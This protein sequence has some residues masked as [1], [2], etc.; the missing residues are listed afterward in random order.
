MPGMRCWDD[1][2]TTVGLPRIKATRPNAIARSLR[3]VARVAMAAITAIAAS[4]SSRD[5]MATPLPTPNVSEGPV[6]AIVPRRNALARSL[7][8][9]A[10]PN[11]QEALR[12]LPYLS[13]AQHEA[14]VEAARAPIARN[15]GT[16][17]ASD[18]GATELVTSLVAIEGQS[19]R[20]D[21]GAQLRGAIA[22]ASV[23]VLSDIFKSNVETI[24]SA[25]NAEGVLAAQAGEVVD[26]FQLG[27]EL[28][29]RIGARIAASARADKVDAPW[30]GA[31]PT[32]P[33]VSFSSVGK[34]PVLPMLGRMKPFFM[35]SGAEFRPAPPPAFGSPAY[36]TALAEIRQFSDTR[37]PTQDSIAKFWAMVTGTLVA[38]YW[39]EVATALIERYRLSDARA[40]HVL[41]LMNAAAMDANIACHDAKYTYWMI[42][43][44]QADA[45]IRTAIGLPN[46]A[47]YPSNH[48]CLSGAAALILASEF[49]AERAELERQAQEAVV[50][51]YYAGLHY[52]FDGDAG[53]EIARKVA[54]LALDKNRRMS[55]KLTLR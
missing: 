7:I 18:N 15:V 44:S 13:L 3:S 4:A 28:G 6:A 23:E 37:T 12:A 32:G 42:R 53:L 31:V 48:A 49:P 22:G 10:K 21:R 1:D 25:L 30:T 47:S 46:H 17:D 19:T 55:G 5:P 50:S 34:P 29:R 2:A 8:V 14:V 36:T 9:T 33:G 11:Q 27:V 51:R 52:R 40:T 45:N 20:I 26:Q 16:N 38:G 54:A 39:N 24:G 43:P 35:T 41:A